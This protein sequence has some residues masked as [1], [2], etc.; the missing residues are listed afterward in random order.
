VVDEPRPLAQVG[1]F[2]VR[3]GCQEALDFCLQLAERKQFVNQ[4]AYQIGDSGSGGKIPRHQD[5]WRIRPLS[6]DGPSERQSIRHMGRHHDFNESEINLWVRRKLV[7][8]HNGV[9]GRKD[10]V[11]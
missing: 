11:P 3:S 8:C 4:T 5:Q 7:K 6:P 2:S 1:N 9:R 10:I